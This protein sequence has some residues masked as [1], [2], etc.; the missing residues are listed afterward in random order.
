MAPKCAEV[1]EEFRPSRDDLRP[2]LPPVEEPRLP[3]QPRRLPDIVFRVVV[4]PYPNLHLLPSRP[5]LPFRPPVRR[6]RLTPE[7]QADIDRI[8]ARNQRLPP[9]NPSEPSS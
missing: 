9:S 1:P 4:N 3:P 8:T 6:L 7:L 2:F 5:R